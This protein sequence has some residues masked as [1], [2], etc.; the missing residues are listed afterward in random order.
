[1]TGSEQRSLPLLVA[2]T[3]PILAVLV[4]GAAP[5]GHIP[6]ALLALALAAPIAA[7]WRLADGDLDAVRLPLLLGG[8]VISGAA[9][10]DALLSSEPSTFALNV[11]AA[12]LASVV[13]CW[14]AARRRGRQILI[15]G[16]T[17]LLAVLGTYSLLLWTSGAET[18]VGT[19]LGGEGFARRIFPAAFGHPNQFAATLGMLLP[20]TF[21]TA[22]APSGWKKRALLLGVGLIGFAA[23][24]L[25]Y[26]RNFWIAVALA[27]AIVCLTS[28]LGR[29]VLIMGTV[30]VLA[31]APFAAS[32]FTETPLSGGRVEIWQQA[33]QVIA[34]HPWAGTGLESFP[35]FSRALTLPDTADA[36]P[37]AH[38]LFL[39]AA[40][41]L[42][43][44]AALALVVVLLTLIVAL[45]RRVF[46][47]RDELRPIAAGCL[48]ALVVVVAG[49]MF[50]AVVFHNVPTLLI[51]AAILGISASVT[52]RPPPS[53]QVGHLGEEGRE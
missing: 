1:M 18:G 43:I 38:N 13:V 53:A 14:I 23:L 25:T 9:L 51:A 32:R 2:G 19:D 37:H 6:V 50:D 42:G 44:P 15:G 29:A 41:E 20:L 8:L 22:I 26:S 35:Q 39:T 28:R 30:A 33:I 4:I 21:A 5:E 7:S 45:V 12:P 10:G 47:E 49:G 31:A 27:L 17:L 48:G 3:A 16:S 52:A 46:V 24:L 11:A 36:P 40:T 34:E